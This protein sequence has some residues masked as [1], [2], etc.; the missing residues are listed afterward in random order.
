[1]IFPIGDDQV[2]G[3]HFPLLSYSFIALNVGIFLFQ[4]SLP[5]NQLNAFIFEY[6]SIP[7]ETMQGKDLFTLVTSMFLHGG[8]MHLIGNMLF[9]WVFADNIEATIGSFRFFIFYLLGGLAAHA[10]HIYFN[11]YSE[12]PTVGASGAISAVMG[13]YLVM[14][15]T[16]RIRVLFIIFSFNVSA[17]IFLGLWIWQQWMSGTAALEV[18]TAETAGVAWWAH[19]G[20]FAFGL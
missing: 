9:L 8:W 16:S 17:Y 5:P 11:L 15:P 13:A 18:N 10:A 20:G 3:G 6:G 19:I 12:I 4:I 1:M 2:K 7:V 14:F